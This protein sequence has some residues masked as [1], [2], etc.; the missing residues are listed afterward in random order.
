[1]K[2]VKTFG[3]VARQ[4]VPA[5][6]VCERGERGQDGSDEGDI[7][8]M[9]LV[10]VPIFGDFLVLPGILTEFEL[11]QPNRRAGS[12][13]VKNAILYNVGEARLSGPGS[14]SGL[15]ASDCD[16]R[17]TF[18]ESRRV[19]IIER[20]VSDRV[21]RTCESIHQALQQQRSLRC[22]RQTTDLPY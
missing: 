18:S 20:R 7:D 4:L 21:D 10:S 22:A 19:A 11:G 14:L 1:M 8:R 16:D 2:V 17:P 3:L 13:V 5:G 6:G 9:M 12:G 15:M